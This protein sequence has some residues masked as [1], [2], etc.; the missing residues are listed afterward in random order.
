MAAANMLYN[1]SNKRDA[2]TTY[3]GKTF[4]DMFYNKFIL[5]TQPVNRSF[6]W[7]VYPTLLN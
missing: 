2:L 7:K 5:C 6:N 3:L 1:N 4:I